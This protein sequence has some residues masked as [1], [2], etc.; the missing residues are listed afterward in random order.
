MAPPAATVT[1]DEFE[2]PY[3]TVDLV[4]LTADDEGLHLLVLAR[5]EAPL[6]WALPGAF[7]QMDEDVADT[8]SRVAQEK[9][10][11]QQVPDLIALRPFGTQDRDPRR[12][13]ITLPHLALLPAT[14]TPSAH[15]LAPFAAYRAH[16]HT[17][18]DDGIVCTIEGA[19]VELV[20]DHEQIVREAVHELRRRVQLDDPM[21][22]R[23]LLPD[24]FTLR[25]LQAVHEALTGQ[26]VN[27]DSFRRR[28]LMS[29]RLDQTDQRETD[30]DHRPANLYRW[31]RRA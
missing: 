20:F 3:V 12:R 2:H 14:R 11:L 9:L 22:Y 1:Q 30:V 17:T 28:I 7:V 23:R 4:T 18:D 8:A 31:R 25:H 29:G 26:P 13:V 27:R 16:I 6:G 21:I 19:E 10:G 24:T 15:A 5:D